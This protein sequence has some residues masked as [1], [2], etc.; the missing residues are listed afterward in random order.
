M[1]NNRTKASRLVT[2]SFDGIPRNTL[3][4]IYLVGRNAFLTR[5]LEGMA[6]GL[7]NKP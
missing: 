6:M 2:Y 4:S 5:G 3:T 1:I 7:N